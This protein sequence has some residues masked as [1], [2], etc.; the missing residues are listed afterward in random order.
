MCSGL[1]FGRHRLPKKVL[2]LHIRAERVLAHPLRQAQLE[3]VQRVL[4]GAERLQTRLDRLE[5]TQPSDKT[6]AGSATVAAARRQHTRG[7]KDRG[8]VPK[9][10]KTAKERVVGRA[11]HGLGSLGGGG[12]GVRRDGDG[13]LRRQREE[14]QRSAEV[15]TRGAAGKDVRE[16]LRC[17]RGGPRRRA[18]GGAR[19]GP[20]RRAARSSAPRPAP[21]RRAACR[22]RS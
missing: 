18:P 20:R 19:R 13:D 17:S 15:R 21:P 6:E 16:R 10:S 3:H 4:A 2:K 7:T 9:R 14:L 1:R 11:H 5:A 22:G 12:G 8:T